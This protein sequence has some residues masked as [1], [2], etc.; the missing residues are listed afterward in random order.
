MIN[1]ENLDELCVV[2]LS[3]NVTDIGDSYNSD[4]DIVVRFVKDD[5]SF[6]TGKAVRIYQNKIYLIP[7]THQV[8]STQEAC[9][10]KI[11]L[12]WYF[13]CFQWYNGVESDNYI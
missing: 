9:Y 3:S 4:S 5:G 8:S 12:P 7:Y 11:G 1:Y 10:N 2:N 6:V 13:N